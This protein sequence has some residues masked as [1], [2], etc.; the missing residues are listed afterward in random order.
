MKKAIFVILSFLLVFAGTASAFDHFKSSGH[1]T[2]SSLI[3]TGPGVFAGI[4]VVTNGSTAPQFNV[5]DALVPSVS[6]TQLLP[7]PVVVTTS[8]TDR[9]QIFQPPSGPIIFDDGLY[10]FFNPAYPPSSYTVYYR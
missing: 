5:F 10:I 1:K 8:A 3:A 7:S 9:I 6:A 4:V 2:A